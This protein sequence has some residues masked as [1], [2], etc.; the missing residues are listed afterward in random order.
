MKCGCSVTSCPGHYR[1]SMII[2]S[3]F[4]VDS[5]T[6]CE[7]LEVQTLAEININI[8]H[9]DALYIKPYIY[10]YIYIYVPA[11][12]TPWYHFHHCV[13]RAVS[14][15]STQGGPLMAGFTECFAY[16]RHVTIA[17]FLYY[18]SVAVWKLTKHG[19]FAQEEYTTLY[20]CLTD[21]GDKPTNIVIISVTWSRSADDW[22]PGVRSIDQHI[23]YSCLGH[24]TCVVPCSR[25]TC[26]TWIALPPGGRSSASRCAVYLQ[27]QVI[28]V[29]LIHCMLLM[30]ILVLL[31]CHA[32][33]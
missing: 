14:R 31:F 27:P 16:T 26:V 24:S 15:W 23:V 17:I 11:I 32:R 1:I 6:N 3:V 10:I 7:K 25:R 9:I 30:V 4:H 20:L 28:S 5:L 18:L 33:N 29:S 22:Q 8:T 2:I 19:V 21:D 13:I 12:H